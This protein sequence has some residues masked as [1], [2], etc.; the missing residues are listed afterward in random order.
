[1]KKLVFIRH[2]KSSWENLNLSDFDR[3]LNTRGK[4]S[5]PVMSKSISAQGLTPDGILSSSA[6]RAKATAFGV[7]KGL[8][9][10]TS[11]IQ[12]MDNLYHAE[13]DT[14]LK[15]V[16]RLPDEWNTVFLFGHNPGITEIVEYYGDENIGNMP[17]CG[18]ALLEFDIKSWEQTSGGLAKLAWFDYPKKA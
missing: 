6:N 4:E 15:V 3:P 10:S 13:I 7:C 14:W 8:G 16:E 12:L 1:M 11:E 5:I 17:T 18:C 9:I 2:A